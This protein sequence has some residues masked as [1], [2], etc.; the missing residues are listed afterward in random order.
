[1]DADA[2]F[3]YT[4]N[5]LLNSVYVYLCHDGVGTIAKHAS[6]AYRA[7]S[8]F[9]DGVAQLSFRRLLDIVGIAA[10]AATGAAP[11]F[12]TPRSR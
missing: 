4:Q 1:M 3:I 11:R 7:V 2:K 10:K 9:S 5:A 8:A 12:R 6:C